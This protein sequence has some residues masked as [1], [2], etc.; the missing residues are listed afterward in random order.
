M[1]EP[2]K[3]PC[4]ELENSTSKMPEMTVGYVG[5]Q[6][7]ETQALVED[8]RVSSRFQPARASLRGLVAHRLHGSRGDGCLMHDTCRRNYERLDMT[9]LAETVGACQPGESESSV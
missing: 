4:L 9:L 6:S 3:G 2:T 5:S 8:S 7:L 1:G